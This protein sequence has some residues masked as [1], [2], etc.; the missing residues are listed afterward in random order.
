MPALESGSQISG[1]SFPATDGTA[2]FPMVPAQSEKSQVF[3]KALFLGGVASLGV[4]AGF[5]S[6]LT[7][8]KKRDPTSFDKGLLAG[9]ER[10][11]SGGALA[12]RALGWGTLWAVGGVGLLCLTV[13]KIL[14]VQSAGDF[15]R[16]MAAL[17]PRV[18]KKSGDSSQ[19][20]EFASIR[21]FFEYISQETKSK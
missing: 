3:T 7:M 15:R 5:G 17:M 20:T 11:E 13:Y 4:L 21:E 1:M 6:A 10:L 14:D 8:A 18:P 9:A 12:M 19:R 16:K 2:D